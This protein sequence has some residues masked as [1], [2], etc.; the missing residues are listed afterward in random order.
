MR[1][2]AQPRG[3]ISGSAGDREPFRARN[4]LET[5]CQLLRHSGRVSAVATRRAHRRLSIARC[6]R[7][8]DPAR[9]NEVLFSFV[10]RNQPRVLLQ[11]CLA[12]TRLLSSST[13]T[14]AS[15]HVG[16]RD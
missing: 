1:F 9:T 3:H 11:C 13:K 5:V 4:D 16:L 6:S 8:S 14:S 15:R 2:A 12:R 7:D 10:E